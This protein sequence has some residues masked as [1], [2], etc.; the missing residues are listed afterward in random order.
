MQ[1]S[2]VKVGP[3]KGAVEADKLT[4]LNGGRRGRQFRLHPRA[5]SS[6]KWSILSLKV[7]GRNF[8]NDA[9]LQELQ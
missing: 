4:S 3:G 9:R 5:T 1:E 8:K 7:H 2:I 6:S